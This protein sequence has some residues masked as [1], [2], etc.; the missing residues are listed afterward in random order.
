MYRKKQFEGFCVVS[1]A[2][3]L[4]IG[5]CLDS[6]MLCCGGGIALLALGFCISRRH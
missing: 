5:H 2:L 6:W 4:I 1:F 3:G